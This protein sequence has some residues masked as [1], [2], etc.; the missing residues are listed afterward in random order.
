M[1]AKRYLTELI[2]ILLIASVTLFYSCSREEYTLEEIEEIKTDEEN[3]LLSKTVSKPGG[4][5]FEVGKV[6]GE[7]TSSVT[8]DP[9]T[10]NLI[11]AHTDAESMAIIGSLYAYL[12][13]YD[14]YEREWKP[15]LASFKIAADEAAGTLDVIFT[16]RDDAFWTTYG[17]DEKIKVTSDDVVF[18]YNE[19]WGNPETNSSGY[20]GQFIQMED[21]TSAHIDIEKIDDRRFSFHFP[22][23]IANPIL[24]CNMYFG[25]KHQYAPAYEEGGTDAMMDLFTVDTDVSQ[26][27]CIGE[28]YLIEYTPGVRLVYARNPYFYKKDAAGISLPY[29]EKSIA[30]IVPDQNTE[31]L[32]FKNGEKDSY[33]VRP[34]DLEDLLSIE[35]PDYTVYNGG[36]SLRSSFVSFNQNPKALDDKYHQ[37]FSKKEFRQAMSRLLNRE[38]I[39][40]QV[41]RGLAEPA[42]GFFATANPYYNDSLKNE[43]TYDPHKAAELMNSIGITPDENGLMTDENGN[44][45]EFDLVL[46]ADSTVGVDIANI[47]SDECAKAGITVNVK[48]LDFQKVVD[49][50]MSTHDWHSVM[51]SLGTNYW[52]TQG[53]NVWPSDGNLHLW[54]PNQ[55]SPAT[56]WEARVDYLYNEGSFTVDRAKAEVIWDEYQGII[57]E[58]LPVLYLVHPLSFTAVRDKW[59]NVYYDTLGGL[60][61]NY[62]FL[63]EE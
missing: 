37:W 40:K 16:I 31:F 17:S 59:G 57:L 19:V 9:K 52:P 50:L 23:I 1:N 25:P 14:P 8:A 22:R 41:Y 27:A 15:D 21:G 43:Y 61:T 46:G 35:E 56:D 20:N 34:E 33:T 38:R 49:M 10:F 47:I 5:P 51:I 4:V 3:T 11:V 29:R 53:S 32:L 63:K 54:H 6:G 12:A 7:W 62:L 39:I 26:L 44:H 55:E 24:T 48:P 58:Q 2:A 42:L 36:A 30:Q 28:Y 18:W 60:D 13:D 45:I